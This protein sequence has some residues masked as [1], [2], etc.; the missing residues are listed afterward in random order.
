MSSP[1]V[2]GDEMKSQTQA[3]I[4]SLYVFV[5]A[6]H[7]TLALVVL[8]LDRWLKNNT[9]LQTLCDWTVVI[10]GRLSE[11]WGGW[12]WENVKPANALRDASSTHLFI[13]L[14]N[15]WCAP[16]FD[17]G[18]NEAA[19]LRDRGCRYRVRREHTRHQAHQCLHP[20]ISART[21]R[22]WTQGRI[23]FLSSSF[24]PQTQQTVLHHLCRV[25]LVLHLSLMRVCVCVCVCVCFYF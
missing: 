25:H 15:A 10:Q 14:P 7:Y 16:H 21:P 18:S 3:N 9:P 23:D 12:K 20:F 22:R 6:V 4:S 24:P 17:S 2:V 8:G 1:E 11:R 13:R 5:K 19:S